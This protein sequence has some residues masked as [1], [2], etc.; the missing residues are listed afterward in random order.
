MNINYLAR[1]WIVHKVGP[2]GIGL[3]ET[4][5]K[6]F[7]QAEEEDL[8]GDVIPRLLVQF[9]HFF[10]RYAFNELGRKDLFRTQFI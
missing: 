8:T 4:E 9:H 3:H 1:G 10:H 2:V 5:F 6:D 7:T